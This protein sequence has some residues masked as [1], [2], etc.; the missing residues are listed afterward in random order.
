MKKMY[1]VVVAASDGRS[2]E[3]KFICDDL[4]VVVGKYSMFTVEAIEYVGE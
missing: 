4:S 2:I 3:K 1:L